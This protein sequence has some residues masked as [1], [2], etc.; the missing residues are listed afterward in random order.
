VAAVSGVPLGVLRGVASGRLGARGTP[1][2]DDGTDVPVQ[3]TDQGSRGRGRNRGSERIDANPTWQIIRTLQQRNFTLGWIGRERGYVGGLQLDPDRITRRLAEQV[4]ELTGRI[5]DL[6]L[7]EV[8][9]N[10][11]MPTLAQLR[12]AA[13]NKEVA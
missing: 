3:R 6:R 4:R 13:E 12:A 8:P 5:G 2:G 9:K 10:H 1:A 11:T 7:P